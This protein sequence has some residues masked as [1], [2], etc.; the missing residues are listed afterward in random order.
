MSGGADLLRAAG[1]AL[2]GERWQSPLARELGVSARTVRNWCAN[3]HQCPTDIAE[4]LLPCVR[5]RGE[6][7]DEV[8]EKLERMIGGQ[9]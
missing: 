7:I 1:K 9:N 3:K 8:V 5:T 2:Y 6:L 4:Q